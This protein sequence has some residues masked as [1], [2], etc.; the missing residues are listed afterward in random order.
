VEKPPGN[1]KIDHFERGV[2]ARR[3]ILKG[4]LKV[5]LVYLSVFVW[6]RIGRSGGFF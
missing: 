2:I 4:I 1:R 3:I 6:L 5:A